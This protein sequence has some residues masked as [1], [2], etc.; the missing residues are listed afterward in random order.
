MLPRFEVQATVDEI[1]PGKLRV[2]WTDEADEGIGDNRLYTDLT[3]VEW[4]EIEEVIAAEEA[5]IKSVESAAT[6]AVEF[7]RVI[8]EMMDKQYSGENF[9][10]GPLSAFAMLD[11]GI[12]AAVAAPAAAGCVP[13]TSCRGHQ[14]WGGE[15]ICAVRGR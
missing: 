9:D 13:T 6:D 10:E 3:G 7:E 4:T 8:G 1:D 2:I 14:E 5:M 15:S 12:M 11:A